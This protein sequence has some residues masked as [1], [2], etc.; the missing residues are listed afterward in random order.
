MGLQDYVYR[1]KAQSGDSTPHDETGTSGDLSGGTIT[2]V[3]RGSGD[4]A[5]QFSGGPASVSIPSYALQ[6][7]TTGGGFTVAARVRISNYGSTDFQYFVGVG[8]NAATGTTDQGNGVVIGREGVNTMRTRYRNESAPA[9]WTQGT[10][11]VTVVVVSEMN[12]SGGSDRLTTY[13]GATS[14]S[15]VAFNALNNTIDTVWVQAQSGAVVQVADLV[16]WY[17]EL[18]STDCQT[19][20]DSGINA[21]LDA[22]GSADLTHTATLGPVTQSFEAT[23]SAG[24][25]LTHSAVLGAIT[26]TFEASLLPGTTLSH[27]AAL[28][29][30]TGSVVIFDGATITSPPIKRNNGS[31][32]ASATLTWVSILDG[33]TGVQLGLKTSISTDAAGRFAVRDDGMTPGGA[34]ALDWLE[35]TGERGHG[36]GVAT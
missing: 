10:T 19:L 29:A 25:V 36:W 9:S 32:V 17:E 16:V 28:G 8:A 34:Y 24:A 13:R 14:V 1:L 35:S 20:R 33:A 4:Y 3:D 21:T 26:Q 15:T 22:G 11:E 27:S 12:Y 30:V 2:L 18:S 6:T 7:T 5:W 31:L 23:V